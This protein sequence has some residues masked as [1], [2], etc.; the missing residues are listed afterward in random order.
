MK[1]STALFFTLT[2]LS[3]FLL[4][5]AGTSEGTRIRCPKCGSFYDSRQGA[6]TFEWM[7]GN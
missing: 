6:E 1:K 4:G 3:L 2:L 5:C 7:R